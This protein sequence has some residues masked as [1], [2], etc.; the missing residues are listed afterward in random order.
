MGTGITCAVY[1][2]LWRFVSVEYIDAE[3]ATI[4]WLAAHF[5]L[6]PARPLLPHSLAVISHSCVSGA[7]A[8]QVC[9]A[10]APPH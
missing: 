3:K 1:V 4:L 5:G 2:V 6:E 9:V 7:N 10:G 8:G